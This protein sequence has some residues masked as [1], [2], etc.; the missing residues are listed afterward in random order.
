SGADWALGTGRNRAPLCVVAPLPS[1]GIRPAGVATPTDP[2]PGA[3][4]AAAAAWARK[5]GPQGRGVVPRT[6]EGVGGAVDLRPSRRGGADEQCLRAR[7]AARGTMAQ[8]EL[9]LR[10][11]N[12]QPLCRAAA[13]RGRHLSA[14]SAGA[15]GLPGGGG[16]GGTS[17]NGGALAASCWPGG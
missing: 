16:R 17:R 4:G 13:D 11:R 9:W 12:G 15:A 1:P 6:D 2:A 14:A 10:Q 3:A 8:G 5:P 7:L